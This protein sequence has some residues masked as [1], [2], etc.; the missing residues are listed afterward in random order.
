MTAF[1]INIRSEVNVKKLKYYI[2]RFLSSNKSKSRYI[3]VEVVLQSENNKFQIGNSYYINI[4]NE[5]DRKSFQFLIIQNFYANNI[6]GKINKIIFNFV[7]LTKNDYLNYKK[8][9]I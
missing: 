5:I 6:E 1:F 9:L 7:E 8:S 3:K 2:S 4:N